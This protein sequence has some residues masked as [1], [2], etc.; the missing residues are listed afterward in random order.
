MYDLIGDPDGR[1]FLKENNVAGAV[2]E[3]PFLDKDHL[4]SNARSIPDNILIRGGLL[5]DKVRNLNSL[6]PGRGL[7]QLSRAQK[8]NVLREAL[9][10]KTTEKK[11]EIPI[12]VV[13]A[14]NESLSDNEKI[15]E[16][17]KDQAMEMASTFVASADDNG[18]HIADNTYENMWGKEREAIEG[19]VKDAVSS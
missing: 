16:T 6:N 15:M 9:R 11:I 5:F 12:Y 18:H 3:A 4:R 8:K 17:L 1:V 2:L 7:V 19:F 13:L 14:E 10:E